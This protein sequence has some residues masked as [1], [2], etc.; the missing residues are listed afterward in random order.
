[1]GTLDILL[2]SDWDSE[3]NETCD[4][5]GQC[6]RCK[7]EAMYEIALKEQKDSLTV[8]KSLHEVGYRKGKVQAL[9]EVLELLETGKIP[10]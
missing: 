10:E 1:M 9:Q 3:D 6:I 4:K 2:G 8:L 7:V 5:C